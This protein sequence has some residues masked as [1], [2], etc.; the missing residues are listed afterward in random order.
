MRL[1]VPHIQ[2][3]L[4]LFSSAGK[5]HL[6][7]VVHVPDRQDKPYPANGWVYVRIDKQVHEA[8]G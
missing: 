1:C 3:L 4:S 5:Q 8:T 6:S 7:D 2:L